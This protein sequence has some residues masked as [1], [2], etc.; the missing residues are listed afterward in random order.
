MNELTIFKNEQ[1][2][3]IRT[4][5]EN[6]KVLFCGSDVAKA[7]GYSSP[8]DAIT[9]HCKGAV[10]RRLLTKGGEQDVKFIPEGDVYRLIT[11]SKLPTAEK[12]ES[13][14]FDEVLPAKHKTTNNALRED[15]LNINE[16]QVQVFKNEN[17][18]SIRTV[19]IDGEIWFVG[20]D[21]AAALGYGNPRQAL[22]TNVDADDKVVHPMDTP[23]GIQE[24]TL[25]NESGLY[26]LILFSKLPKAKEFKHWVTSEV[27][28]AIRKTGGYVANET[29]LVSPK[30]FM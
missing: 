5:E 10:K 17:F 15:V 26:S 25:I 19:E 27:L 7:L 4:I 9:A 8:K 30:I 22:S 11:H 28:P 24:M 12:F 1:F 6:G 3:E 13:W 29:I 21:V 16:T 2:G 20:K 18:G 23:G 14:V